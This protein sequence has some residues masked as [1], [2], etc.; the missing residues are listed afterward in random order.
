MQVWKKVKYASEHLLRVRWSEAHTPRTF[1]VAEACV[2]N[3]TASKEIG[4]CLD[5]WVS[6]HVP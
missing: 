4:H 3:I 1:T 2:E 5:V 6:F